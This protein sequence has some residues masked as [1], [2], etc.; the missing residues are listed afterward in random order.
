MLN[1]FCSPSEHLTSTRGQFGRPGLFQESHSEGWAGSPSLPHPSSRQNKPLTTVADLQN[2]AEGLQYIT[3]LWSGQ[4]LPERKHLKNVF[5]YFFF[6]PPSLFNV[7]EQPHLLHVS[8]K[9]PGWRYVQPA[10]G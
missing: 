1:Q 6:F 2:A 4:F 5:Q 3:V 9:T 8:S 7:S 10:F